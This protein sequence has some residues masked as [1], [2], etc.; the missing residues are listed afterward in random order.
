MVHTVETYGVR[1]TS[2]GKTLVYTSD[3][4]LNPN[5]IPLM[6][7]ADIVI[8]DA[9][10]LDSRHSERSPHLSVKQLGQATSEAGAKK[11]LLAHLP[12]IE[13][14]EIL[15]EAKEQFKDAYL[16]DDSITYEV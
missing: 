1:V 5:L 13:Q 9:C 4:R 10:I 14:E 15:K 6:K 11:L 7:N 3:S 8:G 12:D 2:S 16:A